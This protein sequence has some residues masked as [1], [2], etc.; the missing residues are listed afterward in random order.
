MSLHFNQHFL[1]LFMEMNE[2]WWRWVGRNG[3]IVIQ[4]LKC[5]KMFQVCVCGNMYLYMRVQR[6]GWASDILFYSCPFYCFE[7]GSLTEPGTCCFGQTDWPR[8]TG[9]LTSLP[10][11]ALRLEVHHCHAN[12]FTWVLG[13]EFQ[14]LCLFSKCSYLLSHLSSRWSKKKNSVAKNRRSIWQFYQL[15]QIKWI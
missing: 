3:L 15:L 11:R 13:T 8:S 4:L 12:L 1:H 9:I 6:L 5:F 2:F 7:T 10:I 14:L